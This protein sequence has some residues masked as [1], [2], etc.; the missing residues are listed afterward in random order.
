MYVSKMAHLLKLTDSPSILVII[1]VETEMRKIEVPLPF[2]PQYCLY[3]S[4]I[5]NKKVYLLTKN[6]TLDMTI[7]SS[8]Y[9]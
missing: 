1:I 7:T 4:Q 2:A 5:N 3:L 6:E 9:M 8:I